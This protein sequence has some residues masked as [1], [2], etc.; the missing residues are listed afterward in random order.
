MLKLGFT[1]TR[2]QLIILIFQALVLEQGLVQ[3]QLMFV[4]FT[5]LCFCL[6][7]QRQGLDIYTAQA[8]LKLTK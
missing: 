2:N 5:H 7:V 1:R 6:F 4:V 3:I 8:I